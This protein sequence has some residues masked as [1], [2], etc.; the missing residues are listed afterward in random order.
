LLESA[1]F[2]D[3]D[4]RR[5]HREFEGRDPRGH[6]AFLRAL[7]IDDDEAKRIR[8]WAKGGGDS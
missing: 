7:Q 6:D 2:T 1:G 5:W 3:E 4:M 8:D